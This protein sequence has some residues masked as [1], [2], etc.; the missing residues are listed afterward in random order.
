MRSPQNLLQ[1]E[2]PQLPQPFSIGEMFLGVICI[3]QQGGPHQLPPWGCTW[4]DAHR[5]P[6]VTV[7]E[8]GAHCCHAA[9]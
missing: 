3:T 9:A 1:V 8:E 5:V 4:G 2:H 6:K 7:L